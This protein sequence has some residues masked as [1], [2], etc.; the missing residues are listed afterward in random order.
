MQ[1]VTRQYLHL[2]RVAT[3]WLITRFVDADASFAYVPWKEEH[4]APAGATPFSMP[5]AELG[6]HDHSGTT[7]DKVMRKYKL[8]DPALVQLA[9]VVRSGVAYVLEGYRPPPEDEI[10]QMAVGLLAFAEGVFL[11][12]QSDDAI[13][14]ASFPVYDALYANFR[15]LALLKA[16]GMAMPDHSDGRGPSKKFEGLRKLYNEGGKP[17]PYGP[18]TNAG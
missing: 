13:L 15:A 14:A 8:D 12:N 7:F 9:S 16:N 6:P 5:G 17:T 10:G 1:W 18:A 4:L 3:P 2:D 11:T